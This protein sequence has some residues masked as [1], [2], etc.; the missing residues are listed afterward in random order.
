MYNLLLLATASDIDL[1]TVYASES[2][3]TVVETEE[4]LMSKV[5]LSFSSSIIV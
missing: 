5:V 4:I 2:P 3:V 1:V